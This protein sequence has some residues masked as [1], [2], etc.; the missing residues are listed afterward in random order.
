MASIYLIRHGQA[1]FGAQD[2]DKLSE[3]GRRQATL[4]GEYLRDTGASV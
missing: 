3:L 1:S 2:Y 4:T